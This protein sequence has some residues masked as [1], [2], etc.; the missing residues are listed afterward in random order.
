MKHWI[1]I[2]VIVIAVFNT[3][4]STAQEFT[5][6]QLSLVDVDS[7]SDEQ[8]SSY[9]NKATS[10]GYSLE[11]LEVLAIAKGIS[12]SQFSKLKQRIASLKYSSPISG[13]QLSATSST[14]GISNLEKFGLEGK[15]AGKVQKS[16]L[17]GYDFFSNPNISFTPNLNL[18]TPTT[19][20]LGPGDEILID[21]W[22]AAQNNY[23]KKVNR[24]GAIRIESIGP[25]YVSGLSV[26]KAKAK[27]ISYLKKIYSGIGASSD[28]YNKV[29]A[30]VSLIG[31]RTIQVNIIG[32]VK[33]PG[34]YALNSLST[35][36]NGLY[37]SGGPTDN[38]TFRNVK[39]VRDGKIHTFFDIY[40]Y[41]INGSE[42]GNSLLRDQD[43]I[44]MMPYASKIEVIGRVKRPGIYELRQGETIK[45]LINYFGGFKA[46]AYRERLLVERVNGKQK[47]V[48]EI[49]LE[50]QG[51]FVLKDG[52]KLTVGIVI[53]RFENRVQ[54][55]GAIYRPGN[56]ELTVGL[57]LAGL[58][59][60]A[61][62]IKE[63]AFLD[64]GIIYRTIDDVK[65][66]MLS[67][68]VKEVL[69]NTS[70]IVLKRE[71]K[72]RIFSK[73][74]LKENQTVTIDGAINNPQT[75][76]FIEKMQI[77]DLIAISGGFKEG[78]DVNVIDISR[79][80]SDGGFVIISK[81][82]KKTSSNKLLING[83]SYFYLEPFDR[84]SVRYLKGY[85]TQLNVT[86]QGEIAYPG[87]Y[88]IT[89]KDERISDLINKAGGF[90]P[91]AY[92]KGATLIRKSKNQN[93][94]DQVDMLQNSIKMDYFVNEDLLNKEH[95]IGVDI[96]MIMSIKGPKSKY[97]LILEEGDILIIPSEKQTIEV[98]GE[99]LLPAVIRYDK[100]NSFKDYI[101]GSGGFSHRA[102][103]GKAY[104]LYANGDIKSTKRF[105]FFKSYP[106]IE[107]GAIILVPQ[108]AERKGTSLSE[109]IGISTALGTLGLLFNAF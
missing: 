6:S 78:A 35:V 11:Q 64:R 85:T 47:E 10:A 76:E 108:R 73:Q 82:I 45:D 20:Q 31:V 86:I 37:A 22:G 18:A 83:D 1:L 92:L 103:K 62:G 23:R 102:K 53:D 79:R 67:F 33:V 80:V 61:A 100:G 106:K 107:P 97:D 87:V 30:E 17:F 56:Y 71:D 7:M 65:E 38:G 13:N 84:V 46:D 75:V 63:N 14:T 26:E 4:Q 48:N 101:N 32:E 52:D 2:L 15:A 105:L 77:E 27:I 54:I 9:W 12:T 55:E 94:N 68:S 98:K 49:V 95:R 41:L 74:S 104:V 50:E 21:I 3:H 28:S 72:I 81:N 90:S 16:A 69:S 96:E 8:I 99:V 24:E 43:I 88:S 36:L 93:K 44:I 66:E 59:E 60:K 42:E 34:T 57:T 51:N 19:Y 40:N 58:I 39:L 5:A 91:F 70:D 25:I 89:T 29:F 109:I